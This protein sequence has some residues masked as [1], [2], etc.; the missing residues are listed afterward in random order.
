MHT[1]WIRVHW[2]GKLD[3]TS[4][5]SWICQGSFLDLWWS[6]DLWSECDPTHYWCWARCET[7]WGE[8]EV[9]KPKNRRSHEIGVA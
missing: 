1:N 8:V 3:A 2:G 6:K 5:L 4:N 7:I 9:G